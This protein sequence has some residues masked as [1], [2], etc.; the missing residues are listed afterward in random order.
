MSNNNR[1]KKSSKQRDVFSYFQK[2]QSK[3]PNSLH[4]S[5]SFEKTI[6]GSQR[7]VNSSENASNIHIIDDEIGSSSDQSEMKAISPKIDNNN[8]EGFSL[9]GNTNH[10]QSQKRKKGQWDIGRQIQ[11]EWSQNFHLLNQYLQKMRKRLHEKLDALYVVGNL[12]R[13]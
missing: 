1:G 7:H 12:E 10:S 2:P 8:V 3:K 4:D 6:S 13:K 11:S 5:S 9:E